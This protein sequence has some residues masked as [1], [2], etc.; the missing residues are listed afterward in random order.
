M[1]IKCAYRVAS[2]HIKCVLLPYDFNKRFQKFDG[3]QLTILFL[4]QM[5]CLLRHTVLSLNQQSLVHFLDGRLLATMALDSSIVSCII[6]Q[7]FVRTWSLALSLIMLNAIATPIRIA[8]GS[9]LCLYLSLCI[10]D[11]MVPISSF[12]ER[13]LEW[14]TVFFF[15]STHV[16][17]Y[18]CSTCLD[19]TYVKPSRDNLNC[20]FVDLNNL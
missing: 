13:A 4:H 17:Q 18:F 14:Y 8:L 20:R 1:R 9:W 5:I 10:C 3:I 12:M 6:W 15:G 16:Q 19:F 7:Q 11:F 2:Y